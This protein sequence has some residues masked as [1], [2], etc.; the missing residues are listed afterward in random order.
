MFHLNIN[1]ITIL[2]QKILDMRNRLRNTKN[3]KEL[4]KKK[5][6]NESSKLTDMSEIETKLKV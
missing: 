2:E 1:F 5:K 4:I 6:K 3:Y